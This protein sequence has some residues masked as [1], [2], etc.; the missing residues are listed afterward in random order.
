MLTIEN[1]STFDWAN[2]TLPDCIE[3]NCFDTYFT[4]KLFEVFKAELEV[5]DRW[6]LL[7]E[8]IC[9]A[10]DTFVDMEYAG[11]DVSRANLKKVGKMV[12]MTI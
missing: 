5:D 7:T 12:R 4:L 10:S 2:I 11:V 6:K 9:P 8:L 1:P 3:G